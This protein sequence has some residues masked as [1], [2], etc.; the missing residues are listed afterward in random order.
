MGFRIESGPLGFSKMQE[1]G[2]TVF[3]VFPTELAKITSLPS[4]R[5]LLWE[6]LVRVVF[7][8]KDYVFIN[9]SYEVIVR[10]IFV[11]EIEGSLLIIFLSA[12]LIFP[13]IFLSFGSPL[14]LLIF[15]FP[16]TLTCVISIF[17]KIVFS[18]VLRDSTPCYVSP[19]V[20]WSVGPLFGQRPRRGR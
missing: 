3:N 10:R 5:E 9:G 19:S 2:Q 6:F 7:C 15:H 4:E 17:K 11:K 8:M 13:F 14:L 16:C 20:G 12:L 18:R 1:L